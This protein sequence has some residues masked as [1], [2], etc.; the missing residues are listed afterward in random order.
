M[1]WDRVD[2]TGLD[3]TLQPNRAKSRTRQ[4]NSVKWSGVEE[5]AEGTECAV[6]CEECSVHQRVV[7]WAVSGRIIRRLWCRIYY[8]FMSGYGGYLWRIY[9]PI[10]DRI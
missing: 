9:P 8:V 5:N 1:E 7:T 3:W 2:W 6:Y 4:S 10:Y